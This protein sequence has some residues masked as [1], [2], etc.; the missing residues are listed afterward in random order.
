MGSGMSGTTQQYGKPRWY[1]NSKVIWGLFSIVGI[2]VA[3]LHGMAMAQMSRL[4][5]KQEEN[6]QR[7]IRTERDVE[8]MHETLKDIKTDVKELLSR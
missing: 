4:Q 5:V 3:V 6:I 2:L 7:A 8:N 1:D